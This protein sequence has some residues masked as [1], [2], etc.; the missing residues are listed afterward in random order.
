MGG[1]HLFPQKMCHTV[2][3]EVPGRPTKGWPQTVT[4][5]VRLLFPVMA[6]EDRYKYLGVKTG[7]DHTSDLETEVHIR[8]GGHNGVRIDGLAKDGCHP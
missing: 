8:R 2:T 3:R 6:W 1:T 7:A 4:T 5:W